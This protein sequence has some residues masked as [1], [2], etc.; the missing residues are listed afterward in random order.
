MSLSMV[1][2]FHGFIERDV[3]NTLVT[4]I[5]NE[6]LPPRIVNLPNPQRENEQAIF[7]S[8]SAKTKTTKNPNPSTP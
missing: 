8:A 5:R 7:N 2:W 1:S 3:F 4:P 6:R